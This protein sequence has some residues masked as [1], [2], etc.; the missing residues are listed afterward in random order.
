MRQRICDAVGAAIAQGKR[1]GG[2][3]HSSRE[4]GGI[5]ASCALRLGGKDGRRASREVSFDLAVDNEE[6]ASIG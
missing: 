2:W 3:K 6:M 4:P 1:E 5:D